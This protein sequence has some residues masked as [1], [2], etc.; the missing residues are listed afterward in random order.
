MA[1]RLQ[2]VLPNLCCHK[3]NC[4]AVILKLDFAKAFDSYADD[5]LIV[6]NGNRENVAALKEVLDKFAMAT[7]LHNNF[8]KSTMVP[9]NLQ[10]DEISCLASILQCKVESFP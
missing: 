1:N 3:C 8:S 4:K 2:T 7:G 10:E 9:M 6:C 5:T